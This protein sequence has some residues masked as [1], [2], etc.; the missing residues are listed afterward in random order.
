MEREKFKCPGCGEEIMMDIH[1]FVDVSEEPSYKEKVMN[2]SFFLAKCPKCGDETLAEY[3][4]MY[5]DPAKKLTVYMVPG[6][7]ASLLDQLN[8]LE[9]PESAVDS[10]AVFRLVRDGGE[11]LEKILI[12]DGG[13]DDRVIELYKA[14]VYENIKDE[15]P[16]MRRE[17]L[18]YYLDESDEFFIIWDYTNALG[19]QLTVNLD[20]ALYEELVREYLPVLAVSPGKYEEVNGAWLS[21]RVEVD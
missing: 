16:K 10:E 13:R 15:W 17:D 21:E 20:E 1:E 18:L 11:L 3:P 12:F 4:M 6:H 7:D 9:L 8:S 5:M 2:G 19:E 14:L